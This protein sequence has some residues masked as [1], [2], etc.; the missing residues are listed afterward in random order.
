MT[1]THQTILEALEKHGSPSGSEF[2][3]SLWQTHADLEKVMDTEGIRF[4]STEPTA[5]ARNL[6]MTFQASLLTLMDT[7]EI[8][9]NE[10]DRACLK[11]WKIDPKK[12][13]SVDDDWEA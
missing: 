1:Y 11:A 4:L 13:R 7:G 5:I 10:D 8:Y 2:L 3:F 9:A 6:R 12:M